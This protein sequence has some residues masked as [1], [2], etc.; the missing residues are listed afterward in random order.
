MSQN[1]YDDPKFFEGYSRLPRSVAGLSAAPEWEVVRALLPDLK[2]S[3]I[4]D[5]GCGFGAFDRWAIE[6]GASSVVGID[7]S[8][9]MLERARELTATDAIEFRRG[10]LS[11]L[12]VPEQAFDLI[13]SALAFHYIED[14]HKLCRV[15]RSKLRAGGRLVATVEHPIFTAPSQDRWQKTAN[16][17]S[18]WPLDRYFD[19]G[20]RERDWIADG[21]VKFHRTLQT[22]LNT[23]LGTSFNIVGVHEWQPSSAQLAE[24]P[25]WKL[26]LERPMFLI[27]A[28]D[29][30]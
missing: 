8:E 6:Q 4:L 30:C 2:G 9:N 5:L 14:F 23:L 22:Y 28:A 13:Y 17:S 16:D 25:E 19:E 27:F 21:V 11:D 24:N 12:H 3:R 18:I 7:L 26:E 29:A 10:D 20:R 15:M 1:I